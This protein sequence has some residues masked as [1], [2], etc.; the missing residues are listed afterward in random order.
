MVDGLL[1]DIAFFL[2]V[3]LAGEFA[4]MFVIKKDPGGYKFRPLALSR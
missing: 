4:L 1:A 3:S 2:T